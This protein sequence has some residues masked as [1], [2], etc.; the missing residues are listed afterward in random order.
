MKS[1]APVCMELLMS[2]F[3]FGHTGNTLLEQ[4]ES[5]GLEL[6]MKEYIERTSTTNMEA[7][8]APTLAFE[9][10][11]R[12]ENIFVYFEIVYCVL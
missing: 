10:I 6:K 11:F 2:V 5:C 3:F 7:L 9:T 12:Y 1:A 8:S 4:T